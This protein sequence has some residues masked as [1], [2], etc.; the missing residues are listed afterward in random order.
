MY[1]TAN[2]V[3]MSRTEYLRGLNTTPTGHRV[4]AKSIL[5]LALCKVLRVPQSI[6]E[7]R[8]GNEY[9]HSSLASSPVS[10]QEGRIGS[11]A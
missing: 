8:K 5:Y 9:L 2:G 6:P 3:M 4:I 7:K 10:R 1:G 11:E